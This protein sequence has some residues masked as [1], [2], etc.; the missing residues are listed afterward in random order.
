MKTTLPLPQE[1]KLSILC[2]VEP[3][4]LGP[5]GA[6]HIVEFCAFTQKAI[7]SIHSDFVHW[8]IV[9]R[10][11]KSLPEMAYQINQK[12]LNHDKAAKYLALFNKNLDEFEGRL[13]ESLAHLINQYLGRK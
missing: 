12:K 4:C 6:D 5:D 1:K 10:D 13:H 9:P 11:D 2:R 8:S 7:E 3:G